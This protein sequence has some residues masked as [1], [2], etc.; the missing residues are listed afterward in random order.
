[1]PKDEFERLERQ[2]R[3]RPLFLERPRRAPV[4]AF[5]VL[6]VGIA[7]FLAYAALGPVDLGRLAERVMGRSEAIAESPQDPALTSRDR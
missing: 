4:W 2:W 5:A 1:V 6:L 7:V 3:E